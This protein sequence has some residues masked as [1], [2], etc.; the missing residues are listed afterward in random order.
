MAMENEDK[1]FTTNVL[2]TCIAPNL[3]SKSHKVL[4]NAFPCIRNSI[5]NFHDV[6]E[7]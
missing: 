3:Q 2:S 7:I 5:S 6:L 4:K 1:P